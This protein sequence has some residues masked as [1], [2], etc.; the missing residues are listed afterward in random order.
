[1][2]FFPV[3]FPIF[4]SSFFHFFRSADSK[5]GHHSE[6]SP[7]ISYE[8]LIGFDTSSSLANTNQLFFWHIDQN[9]HC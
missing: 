3:I 4:A 1:M 2:F 7:C 8:H 9:I 5:Y 6:L